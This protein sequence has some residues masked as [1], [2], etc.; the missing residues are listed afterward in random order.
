MTSK[1]YGT[2][3]FSVKAGKSYKIYSASS[4]LGFYGFEYTYGS[5]EPASGMVKLAEGTV[6]ADNWTAKAGDATEFT[7]L[8]LEGVIEGTKVTVKY[9]GEHRVKSVTAVVK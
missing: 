6:D 2:F 7:P 4:K 1:Y 9:G 3:N 8:P 5:A